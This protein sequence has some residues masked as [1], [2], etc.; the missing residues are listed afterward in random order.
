MILTCL[1]VLTLFSSSLGFKVLFFSP[2]VGFSHLK[3]NGL[4]ADL[5][6]QAGHDVDFIVPVW[7]PFEKSNGSKLANVIRY[8]GKKMWQIANALTPM[9]VDLFNENADIGNSKNIAAFGEAFRF[10]CESVLEDKVLM[11]YLRR[12]KYAVGFAEYYDGCSFGL[13]RVLRVYSTIQLSAITIC[14][15]TAYIHGLSSTTSYIPSMSNQEQLTPLSNPLE[16]ARNLY[17]NLRYNWFI[18]P[19]LMRPTDEVFKR[20]INPEFPSLSELLRDVSYVFV[21][22]NQQ[23]EFSRPV[24]SKFIFIGGIAVTPNNQLNN[25]TKSMLENSKKGVVL[26]SFGSLI[27]SADI[28][29]PFLRTFLETFTEFPEYTFIWKFSS[30]NSTVNDLLANYP[31]VKTVEWIDQQSVLAHPK[32]KAFITHVGVN[33][34]NEAAYFAVPIVAIPFFGDQPYNSASAIE[35]GIAVAVDRKTISTKSLI[36]AL[37]EVLQSEQIRKNLNVLRQKLRTPPLKA[38][39]MFVKTIEYAA[40]F[41]G[42]RRSTMKSPSMNTIEYFCLDSIF[43]LSFT[44]TLFVLFVF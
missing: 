24:S 42:M 31:N 39:E 41:D 22:T 27:D 35:R 13:F 26:V 23:L 25:G 14:E 18:A 10:H 3:F 21:N 29:I 40:R 37:R 32:T 2:T 1:Y 36:A 8:E 16:R 7:N 17:F 12:Q 43:L 11:D 30:A 6:V 44:L 34:L 5:L 28:K 9:K 4:L 15:Q 38:E 20:L 19:E 33:G